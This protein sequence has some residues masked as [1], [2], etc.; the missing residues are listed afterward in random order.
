MA[1]LVR[2]PQFQFLGWDGGYYLV[3]IIF[4]EEKVINEK[5]YTEI[6][7]NEKILSKRGLILRI[8]PEDL[9]RHSMDATLCQFDLGSA[10]NKNS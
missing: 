2:D 1:M 9:P 7:E 6:Q 5:E 3:K 4:I 10:W 8:R